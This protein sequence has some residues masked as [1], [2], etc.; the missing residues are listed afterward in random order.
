MAAEGAGG[1]AGGAISAGA[2]LIGT[3]LQ[4]QASREMGR[5][6]RVRAE[7]Q[8]VM[9]EF[10]AVE[11]ERRAGA[12]IAISQRQASEERRQAN[13]VASR[14]LAVAASSGGGVNDPTMIRVIA[15]ARGEGAVRAANALYEGEARAR[16]L[17]TEA[18]MGRLTS[19]EGL[20][21]AAGIQEGHAL[22]SMGTIAKEGASL[23]SR[24]GMN[25]PKGDAALVPEQARGQFDLENRQYGG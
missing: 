12:S 25:G 20:I 19:T 14:A 7:Q 16:Q 10:E 24:Y 2:S 5:V 4:V 15:N 8:R 11:A 1:G 6:A 17:R 22:A 21:N 18:A 9:A 23:Y 3:Y 13:L